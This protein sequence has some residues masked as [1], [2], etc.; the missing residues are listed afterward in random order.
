MKNGHTHTAIQVATG[1][2][3]QAEFANRLNLNPATVSR[4]LARYYED[5]IK[6]LQRECNSVQQQ[7]NAVQSE[8]NVLQE[9]CKA[10]ESEL[11]EV[12][13]YASRWQGQ[14]AL[15]QRLASVHASTAML[16]LLAAFEGV[17]SF[18]LLQHK[19][20]A[21]ALPVSIAIA[22]ALLHFTAK[23]NSLGK[24]FCI[25][26]AMAVGG[27]YFDVIPRNASN[28]LFAF[29]PPTIA[30]LIAFTWTKQASRTNT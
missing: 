21:L 3:T 24:W 30:A 22:F 28:Y 15:I 29:V 9:R 17:G 18:H 6:S 13:Q 23:Q 5:A 1:E 16:F 19:G 8:C 2:I 20:V 7:R 26:F 27:I 25:V 10:L 12:Q 11:R 14:P 4:N